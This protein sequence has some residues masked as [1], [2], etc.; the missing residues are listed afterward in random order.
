MLEI[1]GARGADNRKSLD[2]KKGQQAG[3]ITINNSQRVSPDPHGGMMMAAS[4]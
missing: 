2:F 3:K 4:S 1:S